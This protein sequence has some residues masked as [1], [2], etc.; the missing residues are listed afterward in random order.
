[1]GQTTTKV[2][3]YSVFLCIWSS[4]KRKDIGLGNIEGPYPGP[5]IFRVGLRGQFTLITGAE[6]QSTPIFTQDKWIIVKMFSSNR[7]AWGPY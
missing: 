2:K 1:M 3:I 4:M 6:A 7:G 5:D